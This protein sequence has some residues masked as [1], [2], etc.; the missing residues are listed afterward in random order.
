MAAIFS[1][2]CLLFFSTTAHA[3]QRSVAGIITNEDH[4][5]LEGVSVIEKG[6]N[7]GTSTDL[8]GKFE[9]QV[10]NSTAVLVISYV[11]YKEK[12]V[13][14]NNQASIEISLESN[15]R[16]LGDVVV[17]G[18]GTQKKETV[19]GSVSSIKGSELVNTK[20]ENVE[21][22]LTG[23]LPGVRVVQKSGEPGAFNNV[24]DIRGYGG[25][26][27][28]IVDGIPRDNITSL[29]ANEIESISVL[30]DAS[31]A[32]YGV[33]AANGVVL[34][35][36]KKG[37]IGKVELNYSLNYGIQ[38]ALGL[39]RSSDA[40]TQMLLK[41]E[42]TMDQFENPFLSYSDEAMKP[43]LTGEKKS[44]DWQGAALKKFA[45]ISQQNLSAS[46]GTDRLRYYFDFG[47]LKQGG[48]WKSNDLNYLK[49]NFR[50]NV[51][52]QISKKLK[53]DFKVAAIMDEANKPYQSSDQVFKSLWRQS[54][55]MPVYA[56]NDLKYPGTAFD[57]AN[58][59]V[60]TNSDMS[61]YQKNDNKWLQSSF[62]LTYTPVEGL[63]VRGMYSFDDKN[64]KGKGFKKEYAL[65]SYDELNKTYNSTVAQSPSTIGRSTSETNNSL[66]Q[67]SLNYK[68]KFGKHNL[69]GLLLYEEGTSSGDNFSANR[70]LSIIIDQLF[71]GNSL[72]Q[73]GTMDPN[74]V[75]KYA[76]KSLVGRL[77]YDFDKRF[78]AE[79]SFRYDGSS[80]FTKSKQWGFF[81]AASVGWVISNENFLKNSHSLSFISNLKLRASYGQMGD[82]GALSFQ[83]L[84]G[85]NYPV[86]GYMWNG[87]F[88]NGIGF[89]PVAN[90]NISWITASMVN[91][92]LDASFWNDKLELTLDMFRRDRNGLLAQRNGTLP[93]TVGIQ[94][95]QEN[96]N[97][98]RTSGFEIAL[99]HRNRIG[100][101][102]TYKISG[103]LS[104]TLSQDRHVE[105]A[106]F[107]N[108]YDNWRWNYSYRNKNLWFGQSVTGVFHSYDEIDNY[109]V[110]QGG[111]NKELLPGDLKMEDWNGDGVIDDNDQHP[112][113]LTSI[114]LINFSSNFGV[115]YKNYDLSFLFQ[116]AGLSFVQ[117]PSQISDPDPWGN[118]NILQDFQ[119]RWHTVDP[120]ADRY[121]PNTKWVAGKR[122]ALGRPTG[123]NSTADI[124]N[125]NYIRLKTL[126]F[127]YTLSKELLSKVGIINCRVYFNAYN[128][129]TVT[130]LNYIDPEHPGEDNGLLYPLNKTFNFG[131]NVTF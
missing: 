108:S 95:P 48:F 77:N 87:A 13:S 17:V 94:F 101:D 11:G 74:G 5:P 47:Y 43:Y 125:A 111:G 81:P 4:M 105:I 117:Y 91:L 128:L 62:G 25:N 37:K 83:F 8:N 96:L 40:Y 30:K 27:L 126:E 53:T 97:S 99:S 57:A 10:S 79:L 89:R 73:V 61:G 112:I 106:S 6:T 100:R 18:Y 123:D 16:S 56:N 9:L 127:G 78:L 88:G 92:G 19:T 90:P 118:G 98:D 33:K 85:Y 75:F 121:D 110:D 104:Y 63:D 39:P 23:K 32:I 46:G 70:E 131:F 103:M 28:I 93:G 34:I 42:M 66:L 64:Y 36:T 38:Q 31:A 60:M 59:V 102:F 71:A 76:T 80:R 69:G 24:F 49:Y 65:Y 12:E 51:D 68:N 15:G 2:Y 14:L 107:G 58:T 21:N 113:A 82:D 29:D 115:T 124:K 20:N 84:S 72:N 52:A 130:G 1:F 109:T 7:K 22:M 26:P 116:G 41:N 67:L 3:Q 114:P 86:G 55:L 122:P 119:D 54:A 129:L 44:S 50:V 35:T 45:P 120:Q